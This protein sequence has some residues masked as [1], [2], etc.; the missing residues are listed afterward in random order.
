M[1][2]PY[3]Y[4]DLIHCC[5]LTEPKNNKKC[6]SVKK[7]DGGVKWKSK[8]CHGNPKNYI[9]QYN[10][11]CPPG[12]GGDQCIMCDLATYKDS[13]G[14]DQCNSCESKKTT[15]RKGSDNSNDCGE[16]VRFFLKTACSESYQ[17]SLLAVLVRTENRSSQ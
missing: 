17:K 7:E 10:N 5:L 11:Y 1:Y 6:A 13:V 15:T 14:N 16:S 9:C 12:Y 2:L 4:V 8:K 3:L